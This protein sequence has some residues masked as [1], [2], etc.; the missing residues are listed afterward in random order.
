[1][2]IPSYFS[3]IIKNHSNII[4]SANYVFKVAKIPFT[5][6]FMDCNSII[7]DSIHAL[8]KD[9]R[10]TNTE[11]IIQSVI[12]GIHTYISLISPTEIVYIAF[13][14]VAPLAK[15]EQQ[16]SR[17]YKSAFLSMV[18]YNAHGH[19]IIHPA[20]TTNHWNTSAITPGTEFMNTLSDRLIREFRG[21][22]IGGANVL[23]TTS[24]EP[25]EGEHKIFEYIREHNVSG[26]VAL[27]G[28]DSDLIMLS[29]LNSSNCKIHICREE[30]DDKNP[31]LLFIDVEEFKKSI[32]KEGCDSDEY[33]VM[34]Y[35]LGNDFL[36]HIISIKIGI[37][38][39]SD[40]LETYFTHIANRGKFIQNGR[41]D[42][43]WFR[44]FLTEMARGEE[45]R[46]IQQYKKRQS[47]KYRKIEKIEEMPRKFLVD[48][49][50]ICPTE[51]GWETRYNRIA[52]DADVATVTA[53]YIRG[54]QWV[55]EYY[56]YGCKNW[57]WRYRYRNAPLL[58]D[59]IC[60]KWDTK[61]PEPKIPA[62]KA[63]SQLF[64]VLPENCYEL[65]PESAKKMRRKHPEYFPK[66]ENIQYKWMFCNYLW[67]CP[68]VLPEIP[69]ELLRIEE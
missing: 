41:L 14:G 16:R 27:Y 1:M 23:I 4:R 46:I 9:G 13:D 55:Y 7:Y 66:V 8:E 6:L 11:E 21:K 18:H 33:V 28:K 10:T 22:S 45:R 63:A 24:S 40:M 48:E 39:I 51:P 47:G 31:E 25:G 54:I 60:Q 50:Y 69:V 52:L 42:E 59:I 53:E 57:R 32:R 43:H 44:V 34:C 36:P 37:N 12:L 67:E 49:E 17:R 29:I 26:Q 15:M 65:L 64:Y 68:V 5:S 58:K 62:C 2:G 35:L 19:P 3:Y 20:A 61:T 30:I 38:S 56:K